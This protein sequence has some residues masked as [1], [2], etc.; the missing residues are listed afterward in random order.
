MAKKLSNDEIIQKTKGKSKVTKLSNITLMVIF[1]AIFCV[2][3]FVLGIMLSLQPAP[4]IIMLIVFVVGGAFV[5][6][7][8]AGIIRFG[9]DMDR[10]Q[11]EHHQKAK[12][13][14]RKAK[15]KEVDDYMEFK[16][17]QAEGTQ[18]EQES[19]QSLKPILILCK[20]MI[21]ADGKEDIEEKMR[22]MEY[23][24]NINANELWLEKLDE[25]YR[26][27]IEI[28]DSDCSVESACESIS[29]SMP[30]EI[31]QI[32]DLL[33]NIMNADDK[34]TNAEITLYRKIES[35]LKNS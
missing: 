26:I 5:G 13:R 9:A 6:K 15:Q 14:E 27:D 19:L 18:K 30:S 3:G 34:M 32:L 31:P 25:C 29:Q 1:G 16:K 4:F 33:K 2:I 21:Y 24:S 23:F 12:E 28:S 17:Y 22:M 11:A 8:I 10:H 20:Q 7:Y 35:L